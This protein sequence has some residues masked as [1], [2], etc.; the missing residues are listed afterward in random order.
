[1]NTRSTVHGPRRTLA[2]D[3]VGRRVLCCRS[4]L[5]VSHLPVRGAEKR[6]SAMVLPKPT[7]ALVAPHIGASRLG[8]WVYRTPVANQGRRRSVTLRGRFFCAC[9]AAHRSAQAEQPAPA[10]AMKSHSAV[11]RRQSRDTQRSRRITFWQIMLRS[12]SR[13][14]AKP[15]RTQVLTGVSLMVRDD[16]APTRIQRAFARYSSSECD[17]RTTTS[18]HDLDI[19]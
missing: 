5:L 6:L 1:M 11:Q 14:A 10:T 4:G 8:C 18:A 12:R 3:P 2:V 17:L 7:A 13:K 9:H 19:R 16:Q 15:P